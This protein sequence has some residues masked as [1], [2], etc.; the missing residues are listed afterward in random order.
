M[1]GWTI[2]ELQTLVRVLAGA[3]IFMSLMLA[4]VVIRARILKEQLSKA[5]YQE[6]QVRQ[7]MGEC[8]H[9]FGHGEVTLGTDQPTQTL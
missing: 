1:E 7:K 2:A 8:P 4:A 6:R 9:C 3:F 5:R